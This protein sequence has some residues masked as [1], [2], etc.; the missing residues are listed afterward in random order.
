MI[1][2]IKEGNGNHH[3]KNK[4]YYKEITFLYYY[5]DSRTLLFYKEAKNAETVLESPVHLLSIFTRQGSH[6]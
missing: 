6:K 4:N 3:Q 2:Y 5:P 1:K